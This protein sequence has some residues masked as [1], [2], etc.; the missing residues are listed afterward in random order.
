MGSPGSTQMLEHGALRRT[1]GRADIV[2]LAVGAIISIDTI[3]QIA[4]SG[5]AEAFT[6]TLVI[7]VTFLLPYGMVT[8]ELGSA[9]PG[10]GGPYLWVRMAF[11]RFAGAIT[12]MLYWVTNP[13]WMGGSLAFIAAETWNGYVTRS[14]A[15]SAGDLVFKICFIWI[16]IGIAVISLQRGKVVIA[17]GAIAKLALVVLVV[18]TVAAYA[19]QHGLHGAAA[20]AFAPTLGGFLAVTPIVLFAVVGFEAPNGA[21]GEMRDPQRDVPRAVAASGAIAA[22]AY[23]VPVFAILTVLPSAKIEGASGFL[24]AASL[25]FDVYGPAAPALRVIAALV[26]VFVVLTQASAWMVASDRVQAAAAAERAFFRYFGRFSD[27]L[28]TPVRMNVL[29][30]IVSTAFCIAATLLLHGST[31]AVFTVVLT[32]AVST[33]LVSYLVIFPAAVAL[34]LKFPS[35]ERPFRV[36]GGA[37]GLVTCT[38]VIFLWVLLGSWV[39]VFP[40]TLE[41]V[42][43]IH[44]DFLDTWGVDRTTFEL[45]TIGTL[46]AVCLLAVVGYL[47]ERRR[48]P[49]LSPQP[50]PIDAAETTRTD[51]R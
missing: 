9:F 27:R 3:A 25:V 32:V 34:R 29:S 6:W 16:A 23:L 51:D 17:I 49:T 35:V 39:A 13:I 4:A 33:L 11:G 10:E 36:P 30:G 48:R 7:V 5:G 12:S 21:G 28:G 2:L 15:G 43:G 24:D 31:S 1:L 40:G 8:A 42:F 45:F 50:T 37:A 14:A 38:V 18:V 26:F 22:L 47:A 46:V 44:Y 19:A 20:G 41:T